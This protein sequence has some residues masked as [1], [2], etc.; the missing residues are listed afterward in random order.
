MVRNAFISHK[1]NLK[2]VLG[3]VTLGLLLTLVNASE[4]LDFVLR[5][6]RL[7]QHQAPLFLDYS[8]QRQDEEVSCLVT[9]PSE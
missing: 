9:G 4:S 2:R 6:L 3:L 5:P 1:M 8:I 7:P